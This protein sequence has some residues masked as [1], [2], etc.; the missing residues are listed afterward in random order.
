MYIKTFK[1]LS[2]E[3]QA[4]IDDLAQKYSKIL[5][6]RARRDNKKAVEAILAKGVKIIKTKPES[7]TDYYA[8]GRKVWKS[9][10]GKLYSQELLDQVH[11]Y[12]KEYRSGNK[13]N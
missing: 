13:T 5:L 7:L 3:D 2:A 4:T 11:A 8:K 1:K 6:S 9:L 12:I 10:T